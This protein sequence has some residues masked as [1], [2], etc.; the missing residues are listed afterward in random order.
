L[1][2]VQGVATLLHVDVEAR[3]DAI[4]KRLR[5]DLPEV[6]LRELAV[7]CLRAA[8]ILRTEGDVPAPEPDR[9]HFKLSDGGGRPGRVH[10]LGPRVFR[11]H[12]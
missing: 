6:D 3:A 5:S 1:Y 10:E 4:V 8:T 9:R 2:K 12:W 7:V 11:T